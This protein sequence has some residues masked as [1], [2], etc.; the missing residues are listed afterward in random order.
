MAECR[1]NLLQVLHPIA[2]FYQYRAGGRLATRR[3]LTLLLHRRKIVVVSFWVAILMLSA[4]VHNAMRGATESMWPS[5]PS[6]LGASPEWS[7][8]TIREHFAGTGDFFAD[9]RISAKTSSRS[10]KGSSFSAAVVYLTGGTS[11]RTIDTIASMETL[12]RYMPFKR[13]YPILLMHNG[14]LADPV[15]Q[16]AFLLRWTDRIEELR[17]VSEKHVW[18]RMEAMRAVIEFVQVDLIPPEDAMRLGLH[19]L[20]PVFSKVWPG[21]L[22]STV[23]WEQRC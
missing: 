10:P 1:A 18:K 5:L 20:A 8:Q 9:G 7:W 3:M 2:L 14:D 22:R 19:D 13:P 23:S 16:Q 15:Y 4:I 11:S 21:K 17:N 6:T 12:A